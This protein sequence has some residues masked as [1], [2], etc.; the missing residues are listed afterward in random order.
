MK[1]IVL[2]GGSG[3]RL[4]PVT[5][6]VNKQVVAHLRQTDERIDIERINEINN[7]DIR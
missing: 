2:A 4:Y 1:G 3:P 5:K 7:N 6:G